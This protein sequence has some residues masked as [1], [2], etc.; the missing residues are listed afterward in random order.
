[1][2]KLIMLLFC[3]YLAV[4]MAQA[5]SYFGKELIVGANYT[6]KFDIDPDLY[7]E[8]YLQHVL[9]TNIAVSITKHYYLGISYFGIATRD[10]YFPNNKH[11]FSMTGIFNQFQFFKWPNGHMHAEVSGHYGNFCSCGLE[12]PYKLEGL[13]YIGYGGGAEL[14]IYKGLFLDVGFYNY[15]I[16]SDVPRKYN[17][18]QYVIGL[19]YHFGRKEP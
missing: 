8:W 14:K 16:L 3:L 15:N 10:G 13:F 7:T 5:Q 4:G 2:K 19:N 9:N 11:R 12:D 6:F 17:N 1:M 18:T